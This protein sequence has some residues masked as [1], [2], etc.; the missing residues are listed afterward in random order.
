M[1]P[2]IRKNAMPAISDANLMTCHDAAREIGISTHGVW[3]LA[4]LG[5][6]R[7]VQLPGQGVRFDRRSVGECVA[8]RA[9]VLRAEKARG[10]IRP[11]TA[12]VTGK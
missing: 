3:R 10:K 4:A 7:A 8:E 1:R 6:I 2:P 9:A 12:A 11:R 5:C